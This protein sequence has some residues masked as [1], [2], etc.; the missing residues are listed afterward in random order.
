VVTFRRPTE[1]ARLLESLRGLDF[2]CRGLRVVVVDNDPEQ[3]ARSVVDSARAACPF[4]LDYG[5]EPVPG[6]AVARNRV[7]EM[8]RGAEMLAFIDDDETADPQWLR[9]LVKVQGRFGADLVAGP[10]LPE[11]C[12]TAPS[13][14][15]AGGFFDGPRRP[16]GSPFR[17][18]P[19]SNLLIRLPTTMARLG[20]LFDQRF[21]LSGGED[22]HLC[23][24]AHRAGLKMVWA[25]AAFTKEFFPRSRTSVAWMLERFYSAGSGTALCEVA[26]ARSA[27]R[28][29]AART[30]RIARGAARLLLSLGALIQ[31][32][33]TFRR[34]GVLR[35]LFG[36][37]SGTG[38][39]AGA[40]G[41]QHMR[42]RR[43][44]TAQARR[45]RWFPFDAVGSEI[46][47]PTVLSDP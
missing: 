35:A 28:R 7:V 4:E 9:E 12:P 33:V 46:T 44:D 16:T 31:S 11:F 8:S 1:L 37:A 13:W 15:V 21:G 26:V 2:D 5:V 40:I 45:F 29:L 32:S 23:L 43:P 20:E 14:V 17:F 41:L 38:Q 42:Y 24:R 27:P 25:E 22:S 47:T 34:V 6:I 39:M 3:S 36:L 30:N 19:T 10:V 18:A